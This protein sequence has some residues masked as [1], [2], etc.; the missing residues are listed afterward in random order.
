MKSEISQSR[1]VSVEDLDRIAE[2]LEARTATLAKS[3]QLID[4]IAYYDEYIGTL[5]NALGIAE[6]NE[7]TIC[8]IKGL[9]PIVAAKD[10]SKVAIANIPPKPIAPPRITSA[11]NSSLSKIVFFELL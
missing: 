1:N 9:N 7:G 6:I 10:G 3:S 2:N 4:E 11:V 8:A 5:K